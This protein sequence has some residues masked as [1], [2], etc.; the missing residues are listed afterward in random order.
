MV[1]LF[2]TV[3]MQ[4]NQSRRPGQDAGFFAVES[5]V[6]S[7]MPPFISLLNTDTGKVLPNLKY[8]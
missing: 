1:R 8:H 3:S 2:A 4:G 6:N 5:A 7:G